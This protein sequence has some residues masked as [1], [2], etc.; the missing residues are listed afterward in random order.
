MAGMQPIRSVA[1]V[2]SRKNIRVPGQMNLHHVAF[3][4]LAMELKLVR[5]DN[6][7]PFKSASLMGA[8]KTEPASN[9][10]YLIE[11]A[12]LSRRRTGSIIDSISGTSVLIVFKPPRAVASTNI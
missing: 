6:S 4:K 7:N 9:A 8:P 3:S 5:G 2:I 1:V 11:F 12:V 10:R